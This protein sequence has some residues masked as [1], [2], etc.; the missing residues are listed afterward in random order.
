MSAK[1]I[2]ELQKIAEALRDKLKFIHKSIDNVEKEAVEM[3]EQDIEINSDSEREAL[4]LFDN[5]APVQDKKNEK[6]IKKNKN[7]KE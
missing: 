2:K 3:T 5:V 4:E 7:G 6:K 1:N